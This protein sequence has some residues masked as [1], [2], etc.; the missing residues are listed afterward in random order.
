MQDHERHEPSHVRCSATV[1]S[2]E[3]HKSICYTTVVTKNGY[4]FESVPKGTPRSVANVN[5]CTLVILLNIILSDHQYL[6][7]VGVNLLV[8]KLFIHSK[9]LARFV[10][11]GRPI[12]TS[13]VRT[14][15]P[16]AGVFAAGR[17]SYSGMVRR[18]R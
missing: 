3:P 1:A 13:V 12:V 10:I 17:R 15:I 9:K 11:V 5:E 16:D 8:S 4:A 18:L 14:C 7:E 6:D 2:G